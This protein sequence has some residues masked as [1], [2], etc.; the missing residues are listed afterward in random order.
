MAFCY[1]GGGYKVQTVQKGQASYSSFADEKLAI[2][3]QNG[4]IDATEYI[5]N[6]YKGLVKARARAYFLIGADREDIIYLEK[7]P[8]FDAEGNAI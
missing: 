5:L 6:K 7:L 8:L 3:A 4:D 2:M 1:E